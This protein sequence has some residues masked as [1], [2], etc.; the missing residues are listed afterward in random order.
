[1]DRREPAGPLE[2]GAPDHQEL[3]ARRGEGR[4]WRAL[5]E[6]QRQ[7]GQPGPGDQG[8]GRA[9]RR[10]SRPAGGGTGHTTSSPESSSRATAARTA[11]GSRRTSASRNT[12]TSLFGG[13]QQLRARPRLTEP[14]RR[15]GCRRAGRVHRDQRPPSPSDRRTRRRARRPRPLRPDRARDCRQAPIRDAS[16][17]EPGIS[18][19]DVPGGITPGSTGWTAGGAAARRLSTECSAP[20]TARTVPARSTARPVTPGAGRWAPRT[21]NGRPVAREQVV[22]R[23]RSTKPTWRYSRNARVVRV[24]RGQQHGRVGVMPPASWR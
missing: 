8:F 20:A 4:S 15:Q 3:T 9:A 6:A 7:R 22:W 23:A 10:P 18:T 11:P 14:T 13:G 21:A 16:S 5:G 24:R 1:M 2:R 12:T 19:G 17:R